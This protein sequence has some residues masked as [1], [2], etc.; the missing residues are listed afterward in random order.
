MLETV[1]SH[2]FVCREFGLPSG[3]SQ[4]SVPLIHTHS[5]KMVWKKDWQEGSAALE[6]FVLILGVISVSCLKNRTKDV[7]A[8]GFHSYVLKSTL[9]HLQSLLVQQPPTTLL[10]RL[11]ERAEPSREY[12]YIC[13]RGLKISPCHARPL[14]F[15]Y[16]VLLMATGDMSDMLNHG[17]HQ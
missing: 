10:E 15:T 4:I 14:G 17:T 11:L 12:L 8:P 2:H 7:N 13:C 9:M 3:S 16:S 5:V 1:E 6:P